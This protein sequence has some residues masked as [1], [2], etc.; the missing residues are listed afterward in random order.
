[1][2]LS[3]QKIFLP[4]PH[5]P[6]AALEIPIMAGIQIVKYWLPAGLFIKIFRAY[7]YGFQQS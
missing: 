5:D 3:T 4:I 2:L 1:M 6:D 7:H